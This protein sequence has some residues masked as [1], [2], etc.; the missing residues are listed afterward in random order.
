M[1][2]ILLL[3]VVM[4]SLMTA[5]FSQVAIAK[6]K[7]EDAETAYNAGDFTKAIYKLAES[8]KLF[9]KINSPILHLRILAQDKLFAQTGQVELGFELKRNCATFLKDYAD[10]EALEEKYKEVYRIS[11]NLSEV[12]GSPEELARTNEKRN[13][14]YQESK[15]KYLAVIDKYIT[16]I[17]GRDQLAA[18]QSIEKETEYLPDGYMEVN[19][20]KL[21]GQKISQTERVQDKM[22]HYLEQKL[23][24]GPTYTFISTPG[25]VTWEIGK[26]KYKGGKFEI[27]LWN[28]SLNIFPELAPPTEKDSI[29][30][31]EYSL[32]GKKVLVLTKKNEFRVEKSIYDAQDGLKRYELIKVQVSNNQFYESEIFYKSY[33]AFEGIQFPSIYTLKIRSTTIA[34]PAQ[35]D[36]FIQENKQKV[37]GFYKTS[38]EGIFSMNTAK[39]LQPNDLKTSVTKSAYQITLGSIKLNPSFKE[40]ELEF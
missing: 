28:R 11:E 20:Q 27:D 9:G 39:T 22:K 40:K 3:L 2:K 21:I 12:P 29:A 33:K 17:G 10:V 34:N 37:A 31:E 24:N 6:L 36:L 26:A 15:E 1:K 32:E 13:K 8:E 30:V 38:P 16:A 4:S 23:R 14:A 19:G 7:F 5:G 35:S 25:A 18:V